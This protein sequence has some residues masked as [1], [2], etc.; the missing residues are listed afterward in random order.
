MVGKHYALTERTIK[1][2]IESKLWHL[3][4]KHRWY[5][6]KT[7]I[8][9][10]RCLNAFAKEFKWQGQNS[11]YC[12]CTWDVLVIRWN[13]SRNNTVTRTIAQQRNRVRVKLILICLKITQAHNDVLVILHKS[14]YNYQLNHIC[15]D[16]CSFTLLSYIHLLYRYIY[17]GKLCTKLAVLM[18]SWHHSRDNDMI[19]RYMRLPGHYCG[20]IVIWC[21]EL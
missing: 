21:C 11:Q 4:S 18:R 8:N 10:I 6:T 2:L 12:F 7:I 9:S 13:S 1:A 15:I 16:G 3:L 19:A 17:D 14:M 20:C 5:I